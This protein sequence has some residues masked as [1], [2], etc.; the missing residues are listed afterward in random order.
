MSEQ[1]Q[2]YTEYLQKEADQI[3]AKLEV[4]KKPSFGIMTPQHMVE[5]L[6]QTFKFSIKNYGEP[7]EELVDKQA[8]FK[9]FIFSDAPFKLGDPAKAKLNDL[10]FEN[11]EE[12]RKDLSSAINRFY[13]FFEENPEAK[14]YND[15][16][17]ALSKEELE[18]FHYRH[19]R[20][21]FKQFELI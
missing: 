17:G 1:T 5:H 20:H 10:K 12:A 2:N 18:R 8:Q 19:L 4:D 3:I 9:K 14:P 13:Q 21:H 7:N 16:F 11:L 15:F 6:S